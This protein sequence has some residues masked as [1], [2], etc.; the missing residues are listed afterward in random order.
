M[1]HSRHRARSVKVHFFRVIIDRQREPLL[2]LNIAGTHDKIERLPFDETASPSRYFRSDTGDL[3]VMWSELKTGY[4]NR[5]R[6]LVV[7]ELPD[8]SPAFEYNGAYQIAGLAGTARWVAPTYCVIFPE[9]NVAGMIY[10]AEGP[11]PAQISD[12]FE[13]ESAIGSS[14]KIEFEALVN[15]DIRAQLQRLKSIRK[16]ELQYH[17][18]LVPSLFEGQHA[19]L[20]AAMQALSDVR[21]AA[22][23]TI[24]IDAG[25]KGG[26][27]LSQLK[28]RLMDLINRGPL[29][30]RARR[31]IVTGPDQYTNRS[32]P[33]NLLTEFFTFTKTVSL[34]EGAKH[35]DR[36]AAFLAIEEAHGEHLAQFPSVEITDSE[37]VEERRS[38]G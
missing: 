14:F 6:L 35:L 23:I 28:D 38:L 27:R 37:S 25:M 13:N 29:V 21:E 11:R 4:P 9:D 7:R 31:F 18:A 1:S 33:I 30:G 32:V 22:T 34:T 17:P 2:R 19:D 10:S 3:F 8:A 5:Q 24:K 26:A 36:E 20:D 16:L 15:P 12:Y